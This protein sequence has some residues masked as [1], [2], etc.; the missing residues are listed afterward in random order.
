MSL[1]R[2]ALKKAAD[3]TE[4][5]VPS[6]SDEGTG[7]GKSGTFP[8]KKIGLVLLLLV[9]LCGVL[10]YSFFPGI[11]PLRKTLPPPAPKQL[12]KQIEIKSPEPAAAKAKEL[13]LPKTPEK[14]EG[15]A[16]A[17]RL[18]DQVKK[19]P[20]QGPVKKAEVISTAVPTQFVSPRST[21]RT[22]RRPYQ[23]AR[24][25]IK[26]KP[27]SEISESRQDPAAAAAQEEMDAL[28]VVRLFNDGVRNQ[29]KGLFPQA[30]QSYQEI[31]FIRPNH[32]ETYNNLGLIYQEQKRFTQALE[33]FQKAIGLN[34]RYLKGINNLGLYY[35]N[36]GKLEEAG[37]Q[38]RKTLDL[39]SSFIPAYINLA[40]V[41]NR[42]GQVEQARKVLFKALEYDSESLEA[43]YNLGLFWEKQGVESKA[44]EHY[45]KFVSKAQ[46]PYSELADELK[47]RWPELK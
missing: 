45:K 43:H 31:L 33:M 28:Q 13:A 26:T 34:P 40:V 36:L 38:F 41:L 30:I 47:K 24:P 16:P 1:I 35:L 18:P 5:P 29:Q 7:G 25:V 27:P 23:S 10:V 12:A 32:W 46:G 42:Q 6:H 39:D 11:L 9:V 4:S 37:N 14:V 22:F 2:Q 44:I 17:Q 3:E 19:I 20:K 21:S 8:Y 15:K